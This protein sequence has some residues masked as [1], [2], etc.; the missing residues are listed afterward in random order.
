ML[1]GQDHHLIHHLYPRVP[2]YNYRK[3]FREISDSLIEQ[4]A[5]IQI[6]GIRN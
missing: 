2:F 4:G 1:L 5:S 6:A 3:L